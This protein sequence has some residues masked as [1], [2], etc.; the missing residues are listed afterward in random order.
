M[1]D[2]FQTFTWFQGVVE[3]RQDPLQLGRVRVR[4]V[5][6]HTEY[7]CK[8]QKSSN[9]IPD[10][11]KKYCLDTE[12]LPWAI[13]ASPATAGG[14]MTGIGHS[15]TS[16][17]EGA[18]VIGFF[19]DGASAQF[20]VVTHIIPGVPECPSVEENLYGFDHL[21]KYGSCDSVTNEKLGFVDGRS[22][23]SL[24]NYPR[25]PKSVE[26]KKEGV[27]HGGKFPEG[28]EKPYLTPAQ[29]KSKDADVRAGRG[30]VGVKIE[31]HESAEHYPLH[32]EKNYEY[33]RMAL[34]GQPDSNRLARGLGEV[35]DIDFPERKPAILVPRYDRESRSKVPLL[36]HQK[37]SHISW[38]L[39]NL[40]TNVPTADIPKGVFEFAIP[41]VESF[42]VG[43][44]ELSYLTQDQIG[45]LDSPKITWDEP[46]TSFAPVYPFNHV[47]LTES[48]HLFEIDDTVG[49]ERIHRM[50]RSGT[51]EEFFP[52]GSLVRKIVGDNYTITMINDFVHI[53]G[54]SFQTVDKACKILINSDRQSNNHFDI[55]VGKGG[56]LNVYCE[57]SV[58]IIS[59]QN[60]SI[61][62]KE[63]LKI[64][65]KNLVLDV[66]ERATEVIRGE[67][68]VTVGGDMDLHVSGDFT[69]KTKKN[70]RVEVV[71]NSITEVGQSIL[72]R[73]TGPFT[74]V[75][76]VIHEQPSAVKKGAEMKI[77]D[78]ISRTPKSE[79][80]DPLP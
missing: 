41:R 9:E 49:R 15:G 45:K 55:H 35:K 42:Y 63:S 46:G 72:T 27:F 8:N 80:V 71:G 40:D 54:N 68:D 50:H 39:D 69:A 1:A 11:T 36:S 31:E 4:C 67:R 61:S 28:E 60:V 20:P 65:A 2:S 79:P 21:P 25:M 73:S 23:D 56:N 12:D 78:T 33:L 24:V 29:K 26:L 75:G 48:G 59:D 76:E 17:V 44:S 51:F 64:K 53:E 62:A 3:D 43:P 14:G 66:E 38:R 30:E 57:S 34:T 13:V 18:W 70:S 32:G 37:E 7:K 19:M 6:W 77:S 74:M 47:H 5:G 16:I 10:G 22:K 58:N 52:D